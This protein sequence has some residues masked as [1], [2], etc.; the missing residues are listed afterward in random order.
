MTNTQVSKLRKAFTN[1]SSAN[2]K[3]LKT[4]LHK[5]GQLGGFLVRRLGPLLKTGLPLIGNVLK[6]L[7]ESIL[8]PLELTA[9]ASARDALFIRKCLDLV[10]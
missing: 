6:P 7:A 9:A 4:Q 8:I 2:I 1:N 3:F 10:I 5:I